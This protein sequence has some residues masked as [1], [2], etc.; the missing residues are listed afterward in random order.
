MK[1][2][3]LQEVADTMKVSELTVRRLIRRGLIPAYKL[4]DRGQ[5]RVKE[6]DLDNYV[7]SHSSAR[8]IAAMTPM[9][10]RWSSNE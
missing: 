7:E 6:D 10:C 1:L 3:T 5:F 4:G 2:L 8:R 9:K